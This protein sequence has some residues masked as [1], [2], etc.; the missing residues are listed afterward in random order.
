MS[1]K[2]ILPKKSIDSAFLKLPVPCGKMER[3]KSVLVNLHN[4]RD[5]KR[6]GECHKN[7]PRAFLKGIFNPAHSVQVNCP[8]DLSIFNGNTVSA[9]SVVI[10]EAKSPMWKI[11][12]L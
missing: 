3:F 6:D 9:K 11:M 8:I 10:I 2:L 7:E 4:K 1:I 5:P 12:M